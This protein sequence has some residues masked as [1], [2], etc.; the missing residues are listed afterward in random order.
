MPLVLLACVPL[1]VL[2]Y[3]LARRAAVRRLARERAF[4]WPAVEPPPPDPD[5]QSALGRWL[6]SAGYRGPGAVANFVLLTVLGVGVGLAGGLVL[7]LAGVT[8]RAAAHL[9]E[10][11]AGLDNILLPLAHVLPWTL[12]LVLG[13]LPWVRVRRAR[14]RRE[15]AVEQDLPL[16]LDLFSTLSE[17]GLGFDSALERILQTQPAGRP[18]AEEF[19]TFQKDVLAGRP[20]VPSLRRLG[21]R[22]D[23]VSFSI[24]VSALV[25]AEQTGMGLAEV[26]R[27]QADDLRDRRRERALAL[28][29]AL[30]VKLLFPLILCLLPGIFVVTL[31]PAFYQVFQLADNILQG[32]G[33]R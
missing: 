24:F 28:A 27:R 10:L 2:L 21:R 7:A 11:P 3:L 33:L 15:E 22:L 14:Q 5:E 32:R 9:S 4:E 18:L 16:L 19:R 1:L 25:Q 6:T 23:V 31:G 29:M 30:P 17:A 8:A 12:P 26:L 13:A 20:R